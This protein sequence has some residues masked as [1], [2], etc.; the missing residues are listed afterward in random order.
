[1]S[2]EIVINLETVLKTSPG[3]FQTIYLTF[4]EIIREQEIELSPEMRSFMKGMEVYSEA[5]SYFFLDNFIREPNSIEVLL[6]LV[7]ETTHKLRGQ[8]SDFTI[9]GLWKF[10][11]EL[12]KYG[13]ELKNITKHNKIKK[14]NF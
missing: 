14:N 5:C 2:A 13:D 10:H 8:V 4:E 1:M 9:D 12:A 6:H 3:V 7:K 11:D